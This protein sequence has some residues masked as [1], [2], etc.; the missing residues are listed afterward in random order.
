MPQCSEYSFKH[1]NNILRIKKWQVRQVQRIQ[2]IEIFNK[3]LIKSRDY[4]ERQVQSK[5]RK[6]LS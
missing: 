2:N 1:L 3:L 6:V 5:K 4:K